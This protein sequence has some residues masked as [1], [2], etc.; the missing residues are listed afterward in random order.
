MVERWNEVLYEMVVMM[1]MMVG[2]IDHSYA[3][4]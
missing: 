2:N 1:V 4:L 3:V